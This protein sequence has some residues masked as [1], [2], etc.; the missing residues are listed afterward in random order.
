MAVLRLADDGRLSL[1]DELGRL[2][3]EATAAQGSLTLR[4]LLC[5]TAGP[6]DDVA[7][8]LAPYRPSLDWPTLAHAC[9]ATAPVRPPWQKVSQARLA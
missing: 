7:P 2:V 6:P 5:H 8:E 3:P 4:S 9:I 1:D